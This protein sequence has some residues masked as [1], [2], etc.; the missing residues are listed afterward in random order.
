MKQ[1]VNKYDKIHEEL[2]LQGKFDSY[3]TPIV[4]GKKGYK[5]IDENYR[6]QD[7]NIINNFFA[8]INRGLMNVIQ[9]PFLYFAF[10]TK[11]KGR[12]NLKGI[13]NAITISNHI[14]ALDCMLVRQATPFKRNYFTVAP[15]NNLA[16]FGG[17]YIRSLGALP[18][19]ETTGAHKNFNKN[20]E[21]IL[22]NKKGY[23]HFYAE[24]ALWFRYEKSRPY[25]DGAFH[26]AVKNNV[27]VIPIVFLFK[28]LN[29]FER[30]FRRNKKIIVKV[31]KPVYPDNKL[32]NKE[33]L[34]HIKTQA[35]QQY[36]DEVINFY[37]Y[38]KQTYSYYK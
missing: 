30:L 13:K 2:A 11:I 33:N 18:L 27:P 21:N 36:D 15:H 22:Q 9:P 32:N 5:K 1:K 23:V 37:G 29:K 4:T 12:K 7:K 31:L 6:Y 28:E 25:K 14:H 10:G 35:Q 3:T 24:Q 19:P 38:D 34:E 16:G 8:S 26:Y 17:M 20:I